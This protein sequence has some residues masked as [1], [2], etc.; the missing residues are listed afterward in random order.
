M[1]NSAAVVKPSPS[2]LHLIFCAAGIYGFF[3]T[4]GIL[5]ERITTMEYVSIASSG[6]SGRFKHFQVLNAIQAVFAAL[7]A[8]LQISFQGLPVWRYIR[9]ARY[10]FPL[11]Y[12]PCQDEC[13]DLMNQYNRK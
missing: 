5:Q 8:F 10:S 11:F 13:A 1:S 7:L 4:W 12:K 3:L 2:F 9:C 6:P